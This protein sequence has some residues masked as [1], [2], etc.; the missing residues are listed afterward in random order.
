MKVKL[1][2]IAA[3]HATNQKDGTTGV[4]IQLQ[5]AMGQALL[6]VTPAEAARLNFGDEYVIELHI[7]ETH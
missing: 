4:Q 7:G 3:Q 6:F 5:G 2:Y 1:E